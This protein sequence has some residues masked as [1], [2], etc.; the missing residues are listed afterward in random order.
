MLNVFLTLRD[1]LGQNENFGN[2][3]PFAYR[4]LG[5]HLKLSTI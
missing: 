4:V 2:F 1:A 5:L 3:T